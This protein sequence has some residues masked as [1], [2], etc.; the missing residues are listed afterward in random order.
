MN[1]GKDMEKKNLILSSIFI[2]LSISLSY[3]YLF[4]E[5]QQNKNIYEKIEAGKHVNYLV[6]GDSIGRSSGASDQEHKWF[7]LLEKHLHEKYD[8]T[9]NRHLVVQSGATAFEGL[10]KLKNRVINHPIDIVFIVFGEN[11]RKYMNSM[12]FSRFYQS[13][14]EEIIIRFPSAELIT[15]TE[16]SLDNDEFIK[17]INRI[18][19]KYHATNIDMRV[20]FKKSGL[21]SDQLTKDLVHPNDLGYSLYTTEIEKNIEN[22]IEINKPVLT[23]ILQTDQLTSI[24]MYTK[25]TYKTIDSSFKLKDHHYTTSEI[26]A[27][28][29]FEFKGSFL[30]VN[31]IRSENGG[32]VDVF[33]DDQFVTTLS[34]WWPFKKER[35]LYVSSGLSEGEHIVKF[36]VSLNKSKYNI[37][38]EHLFQISSIITN[39]R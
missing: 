34:L 23:S 10:Y 26:G 11:D 12:D 16:S 19:E 38:N 13:L 8:G 21:S 35:S 4:R 30:G 2:L 39:K 33:I 15:I 28:I 9:F 14:I 22:S 6:V 31:V 7:T 1:E 25:H 36:Q 27:S 18:S 32:M 29:E 37:S 17:V 5:N 24:P 3:L 20:P